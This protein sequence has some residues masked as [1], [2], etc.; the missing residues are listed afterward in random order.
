MSAWTNDE[1]DRIGAADE[2]EVT[3]LRSDGTPRKPVTIWVV[4]NGNDLYVRSWRGPSGA[5]FRSAQPH[6]GGHIKSGGVDK[7]VQFVNA[8]RSID[9]QI[10]AAYR[11]KYTP[12]A[13]SYVEP[14]LT[15]QARAT[16]LQVV[17]R[18]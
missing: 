13:A 12:I 7:D 8:N 16:T 17:P 18:S 2:L 15:A 1:L 10:D 5:W 11:T 14:M 6:H 4:R 9:D 3:T